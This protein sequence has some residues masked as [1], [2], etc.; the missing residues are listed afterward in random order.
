VE[1][2]ATTVDHVHPLGQQ[3]DGDDLVV[4]R[5]DRGVGQTDVAQSRDGDP[6]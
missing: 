2:R 1:G 4:A 6:H 5:Q 3:V